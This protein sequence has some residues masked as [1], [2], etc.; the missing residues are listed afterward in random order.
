MS[1]SSDSP[2]VILHSKLRLCKFVTCL[3]KLCSLQAPRNA[4]AQ[5]VK[6]LQGLQPCAQQ[7]PETIH[8]AVL[9]LLYPGLN[10]TL[11]F[12]HCRPKDPPTLQRFSDSLA[13]MSLG[14]SGGLSTVQRHEAGIRARQ[15]AQVAAAAREVAALDAGAQQDND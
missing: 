10:C 12:C 8:T 6:P 5:A 9:Q 4:L 7:I 1:G 13:K 2:V 15:Q 11:F 14:S 3:P